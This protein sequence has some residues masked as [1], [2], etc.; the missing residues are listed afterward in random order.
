M[1][2]YNKKQTGITQVMTMKLFSSIERKAKSFKIRNKISREDY[3]QNLL[4]KLEEKCYID[5]AI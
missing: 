1:N 2:S 3:I 5:L 4:V